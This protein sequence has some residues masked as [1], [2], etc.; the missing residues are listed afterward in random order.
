M[1]RTLTLI[2][3]VFAIAACSSLRPSADTSAPNR[4]YVEAGYMDSSNGCSIREGYEDCYLVCPAEGTR[5]RL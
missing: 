1:F 4:C 2:T 5:T 3:A